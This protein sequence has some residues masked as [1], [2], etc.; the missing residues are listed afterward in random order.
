MYMLNLL[1]DGS[2]TTNIPGLHVVLMWTMLI[3]KSCQISIVFEQQQSTCG[4]R[5]RTHNGQFGMNIYCEQFVD[6]SEV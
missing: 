3:V 6:C 1:K 4:K 5:S 2:K